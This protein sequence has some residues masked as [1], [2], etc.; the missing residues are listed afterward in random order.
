MRKCGRLAGC[1]LPCR[2]TEVVYG[3]R[4]PAMMKD[5]QWWSWSEGR[6][7]GSESEA[8][9]EGGDRWC[10]LACQEGDEIGWALRTACPT[11]GMFP[12]PEV[13]AKAWAESQF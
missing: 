6:G 9:S 5:E 7:K 11:P 10:S 1:G 4:H 2:V 13:L 8:A 12:L 3:T